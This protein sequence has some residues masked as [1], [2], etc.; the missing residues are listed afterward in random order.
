M[1]FLWLGM[2]TQ[3]TEHCLEQPTASSIVGREE[4]ICPELGKEQLL[5]PIPAEGL[6]HVLTSLISI[7]SLNSAIFS[8]EQNANFPSFL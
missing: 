7:T 5:A 6:E 1:S 3:H 4:Q 2:G 8:A